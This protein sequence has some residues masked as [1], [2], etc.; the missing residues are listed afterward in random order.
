[1]VFMLIRLD[2]GIWIFVSFFEVSKYFF[3]KYYLGVCY[4]GGYWFIWACI[5]VYISI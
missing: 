3:N 2:V 4:G 5:F 1:M